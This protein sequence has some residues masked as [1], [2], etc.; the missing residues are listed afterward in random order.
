[1]LLLPVLWLS[2]PL[3]TLLRKRNAQKHT[4]SR[5]AIDEKETECVRRIEK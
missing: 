3:R 5:Q 4:E 1:M 2:A